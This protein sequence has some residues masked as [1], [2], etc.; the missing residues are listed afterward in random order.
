MAVAFLGSVFM[1]TTLFTIAATL[2]IFS[3]N[4][5][6]LDSNQVV[7]W[8]CVTLLLLYILAFGATWGPVPWAM[9]SEILTGWLRAKGVALSICSNWLYV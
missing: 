9:P 8:A 1:W 5:S 6:D 2:G 4:L 7:G 3:W